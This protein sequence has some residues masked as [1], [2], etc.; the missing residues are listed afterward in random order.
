MEGKAFLDFAKKLLPMRHEPALR[1]AVS[2]G[3]Y[4]V[5]NCAVQLLLDLGFRVDQSAQNHEKIYFDFNNSGIEEIKDMADLLIYLR[6]RRNDADY[7]MM[8]N[9]F[10]DHRKCE[11]DIWQAQF[12]I[13]V[14]ERYAKEPLRA[15]LKNGILEY[16]R[17]I[18]S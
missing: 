7:N 15:Q 6:R 17:K 12:I 10:I 14:L 3:Y 16:H 13:S 18:G 5:Y 2:R 9:E 4:A 1:S 11:A 8:T